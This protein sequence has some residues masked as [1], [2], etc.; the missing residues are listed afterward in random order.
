[1]SHVWPGQYWPMSH[2]QEIA[3]I[4]ELR[5]LAGQPGPFERD[6]V[7]AMVGILRCGAPW[8][9]VLELAPGLNL[10]A[11]LGAYDTLAAGLAESRAAWEQFTTEKTATALVHNASLAARLL[12]VPV[13]RA[14]FTME[15]TPHLLA[16]EAATLEQRVAECTRAANLIEQ[17]LERYRPPS[18]TGMNIGAKLFSPTNPGVYADPFFLADRVTSLSPVRV[19]ELLGTPLA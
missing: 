12:P 10:P 4:A 6:D 8:D 2:A 7:S 15:D 19:A 17:E 16:E 18:N 13:H 9:R 1:M 14:L 3:A 5:T 11:L